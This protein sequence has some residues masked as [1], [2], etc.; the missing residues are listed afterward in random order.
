MKTSDVAFAAVAALCALGLASAANAQD[1]LKVAV[2]QRGNWATS[3]AEVGQRVGIFKK[4]GLTLELLYTQ[5]SGE[6]QQAVIAESVDVGIAAGTMGAMSAF[7][8]GAPV[9]IIS[10]ETTGASDLYWYVK[11]GSPVKTIKD[12]DGRTVAYSTNGSSTHMVVQAFIKQFDLKAKAVATG[13]PIPTLTQVMSGQI[14][15]G[16]S[17]PPDGLD[18]LD[19]GDIRFIANG[20]EAL[21]FKGQTVRVNITNRKTLATR[22]DALQ[23]F[24]KA[25]RETAR[26]LYAGDATLQVYADWLGISTAKAKRTRDE[27]YPWEALDPD[28]IVG[29]EAI[30]SDAVS[31]KYLTTPLTRA[32]LDEL[33]VKLAPQ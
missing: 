32:Q 19:R 2:G 17:A 8:K 21:I 3:V 25:Y 11:A 23:R 18:Q 7:A 15:V 22:V 27:F 14:D 12:F 4:H 10:A 9:R 29:L 16:W 13:G 24:V 31:L 6:T 28:A 20:N 30:A 5:G 1:N 33:V 26:S